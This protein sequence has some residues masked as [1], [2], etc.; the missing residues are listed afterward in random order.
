RTQPLSYYQRNARPVA[1]EI[2]RLDK[3]AVVIPASLIES[4][5]QSRLRFEPRIGR[6]GTKD[7]LY[8]ALEEIELGGCGTAVD[9]AVG[10]DERHGRQSAARDC[11]EEIRGVLY[12]FR[13]LRRVPHD[14][15]R[16]GL[17]VAEF[18]VGFADE[19]V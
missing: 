2:D 14:R 17:E 11:R 1:E 3:T 19:D 4:N 15:R 18:A 7:F 8:H 10:L 13:A 12:V 9:Q 6:K 16:I 5:Q